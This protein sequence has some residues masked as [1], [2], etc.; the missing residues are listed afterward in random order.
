M[1]SASS[2]L[3]PRRGRPKGSK[4]K[5]RPEGA[6]PRGRPRTR[7]RAE[8]DSEEERGKRTSDNST[9]TLPIP[10][11]QNPWS[12]PAAATTSMLTR[13]SAEEEDDEYEQCF[14]TDQ[15][16]PAQQQEMNRIEREALG[17]CPPVAS[18]SAS[19][20][21]DASSSAEQLRER[22]LRSGVHRRKDHQKSPRLN[23]KDSTIL[24]VAHIC[25]TGTRAPVGVPVATSR[26]PVVLRFGALL[27]F[28]GPAARFWRRYPPVSCR[29]GRGLHTR[30]RLLPGVAF[31][32]LWLSG[33]SRASYVSHSPELLLLRS[34]G[35]E[36]LTAACG[37]A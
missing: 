23:T 6:P 11:R 34:R 33:A 4:D 28:G 27:L 30:V 8:S 20:L 14:D 18:T 5:P 25:V 35:Q 12:L 13:S 22:K 36:R 21:P 31:V 2:V 1:D 15:F 19:K 37:H 16:T 24:P 9:R 26:L 17:E 7:D 29:A 32:A 3:K 10:A